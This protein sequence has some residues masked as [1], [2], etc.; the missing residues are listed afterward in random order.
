[1]GSE[2]EKGKGETSKGV[3]SKGGASRGGDHKGKDSK[4]DDSKGKDSKGGKTLP[5]VEEDKEATG[6][7]YS[8]HT[9]RE[10]K[11]GPS[12]RRNDPAHH[13]RGSETALEYGDG[14]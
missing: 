5:K 1:M 3:D 2:S 13:Q 12:N 11:W 4:G 8:S 7:M 6:I 10:Q 9:A 14:S